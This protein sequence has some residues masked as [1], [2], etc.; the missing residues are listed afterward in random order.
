MA[1]SFEPNV[2]AILS[3]TIDTQVHDTNLQPLNIVRLSDPW[4]VHVQ[5]SMTGSIVPLVNGTW[6][7][8]VFAEAIGVGASLLA[9]SLDVAVNDEPLSGLSRSYNRRIVVPANLPGLAEG[10]YRI[11]TVITIDNGGARGMIAAF[12]EGPILQ[13]FQF[14]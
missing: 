8:R 11:T 7:V 1:G 14:P 10:L 5:W 6:H 3:G 13:F 4:H 12:D 2:P 9:A